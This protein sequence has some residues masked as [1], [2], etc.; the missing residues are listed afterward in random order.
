MTE[1]V[2]TALYR[3]YDASGTLLYVGVS[4]NPQRRFWGHKAE[5]PWWSEVSRHTIEWVESEGRA[6]ELERE[7]IS[8]EAPKY[9]L[10]STDAYRAQQSATA[11]A[12]S[13]ERRRAR[14]VGLEARAIQVRTRRELLAQ[15]V[16]K[17]EAER[18][19]L[20]ARERHKE[21]SGLFPRRA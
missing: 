9:N 8:T 17:E 12:I 16:P 18:L 10:R 2:R 20:L 5:K 7:A 6:L 1:H 13:P 19:A 4:N 3:L 21:A 11:K 15:G 14:G